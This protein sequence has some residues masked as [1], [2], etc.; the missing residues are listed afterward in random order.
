MAAFAENGQFLYDGDEFYIELSSRNGSK[1]FTSNKASLFRTYFPT[2]ITLG[3][4]YD[5]ALAQIVL[6]TIWR[7]FT[8]QEEAEL[9]IDYH[10]CEV[11]YDNN[12]GSLCAVN[13]ENP[14][15][16]QHRRVYFPTGCFTSPQEFLDALILNFSTSS[17]NNELYNF[18]KYISIKYLPSTNRF[19]F[20]GTSDLPTNMGVSLNFSTKAGE[21]FGI[22][23]QWL[24]VGAVTRP[25]PDTAKISDYLIYQFNITLDILRFE[26]YQGGFVKHLC[27]MDTRK[28]GRD[29]LTQSIV[30]TPGRTIYKK[31]GVRDFSS[32]EVKIT[33]ERGGEI[34]F[35]PAESNNINETVSILLRF[36]PRY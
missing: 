16:I 21:M 11:T 19:Y 14:V 24:T 27:S 31:M 26:I 36:K 9:Y 23:G 30:F 33:D 4:D 2:P 25:A 3:V 1:H 17:Y 13:L 6:P 12:D 18:E 28:H 22:R 15:K 32:I 34:D 7:T 5:V 29:T 20:S 35:S 8:I 10:W